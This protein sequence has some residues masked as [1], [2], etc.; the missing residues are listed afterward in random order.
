VNGPWPERLLLTIGIAALASWGATSIDAARFQDVALRRLASLRGDH[1]GAGGAARARQEARTTG[2][3]GRIAIPSAGVSAAIA[4]G[5]E[6][7]TLMRAVG[8]V[9]GTAFPGEPGNVALAGHRDRH[10]ERLGRVRRGDT[11]HVET[12]DGAFRYRVEHAW[13]VDPDRVDLLAPTPEP[14]LTLVTCYP[15]GTLGRAP[16]RYVVRAHA[17]DPE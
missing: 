14:A 4:E 12:P 15:F 5:L 3:V 10:F 7:R 13:I 1:D 6:P 9:S 8:H 17:L 2:L 16:S 11:I